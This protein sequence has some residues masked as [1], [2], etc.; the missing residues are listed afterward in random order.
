[1]PLLKKILAAPT[2]FCSSVGLCLTWSSKDSSHNSNEWKVASCFVV[3]WGP[4]FVK[5][6]KLYAKCTQAHTGLRNNKTW[7]RTCQKNMLCLCCPGQQRSFIRKLSPRPHVASDWCPFGG[8]SDVE[9]S[10]IIFSAKQLPFETWR[11]SQKFGPNSP[12]KKKYNI[13]VIQIRKLVLLLISGPEKSPNFIKILSFHIPPVTRFLQGE[14]LG[15][16]IPSRIADGT[17]LTGLPQTLVTT[18]PETISL[19]P[20][21]SNGWSRWNILFRLGR[22]AIFI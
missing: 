15:G 10:W 17:N 22:T 21:N 9:K 19:P 2:V 11:V 1:M 14:S 3:F 4:S 20:E 13:S 6:W 7:R 16:E 5:L 18:I 12:Q 8:S